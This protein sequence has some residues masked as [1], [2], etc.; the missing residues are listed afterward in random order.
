MVLEI[1]GGLFGQKDVRE[2]ITAGTG[3]SYWSCPGVNFKPAAADEPSASYVLGTIGVTVAAPRT[4]SAPVFLP[5]NA[6]IT[7]VI[8]N[9]SSP[10]RVWTMKRIDAAG[11]STTMATAN[12]NTADT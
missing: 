8:V 4:V 3:T 2:T 6:I 9:G 7:S 12:I 10:T 1:P 5:H 11:S